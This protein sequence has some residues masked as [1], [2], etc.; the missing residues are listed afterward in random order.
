M[1]EAEIKVLIVDDIP[2]TR[3]MLKKLL[4]FENDIQVVGAATTGREGVDL[5]TEEKPDIFLM[6]INMPDMDGITATEE[7][8]KYAPAA[9]VIMMSVQSEADYLR[10]AM[11]AGARDYLTKPISGE[12]L[13]ETIRRVFESMEGERSQ[14]ANAPTKGGTTGK[15][16]PVGAALGISSQ[17]TA[18]KGALV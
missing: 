16:I 18:R 13:S 7:I 17:S 3:E 9:G 4:M 2:E 15:P 11:I 8:K 5:A 6:D 10:R 12:D 1:A 14:A